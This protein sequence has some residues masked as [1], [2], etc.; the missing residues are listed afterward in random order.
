M[1]EVH[2]PPDVNS[3]QPQPILLQRLGTLEQQLGACQ[4]AAQGCMDDAVHAG[5]DGHGPTLMRAA[6]AGKAANPRAL[7]RI[8]ASRDVHRRGSPVW[9]HCPEHG[10]LF[11]A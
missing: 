3:E 11:V 9:R 4:V 10:L 5:L 8:P 1:E 2:Q 6:T 7:L